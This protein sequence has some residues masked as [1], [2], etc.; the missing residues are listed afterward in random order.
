MVEKIVPGKAEIISMRPVYLDKN[1]LNTPSI[2]ISLAVKEVVRMGELAR[3]D[4]RLG[5][6]A[7]QSFDADKVKYV[8]EHEPV[9]DALERDITDYLTQMSSSEMSESLTTRHTGLLHA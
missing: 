5:M 2:A 6:E 1:M 8:L 7:I 9:V 4:V 3:K